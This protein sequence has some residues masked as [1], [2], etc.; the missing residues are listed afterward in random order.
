MRFV[1]RGVWSRKG[2]PCDYSAVVPGV[3]IEVDHHK[4]VR[5]ASGLI[6]GANEQ[7]FWLRSLA[8][9]HP[10]L[11]PPATARRD[12]CK[13]SLLQSPRVAT[14]LAKTCALLSSIHIRLLEGARPLPKKE[15]CFR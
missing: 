10:P 9:S 1:S 12:R 15:R 5:R 7:V 4:K 2:C 14:I 13:S 3:L 8:R 11:H 6:A